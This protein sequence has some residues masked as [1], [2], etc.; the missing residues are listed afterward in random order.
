MKSQ[1][2]DQRTGAGLAGLSTAEF[3]G[4]GVFTL[5]L[6]CAGALLLA[7]LLLA[8]KAAAQETPAP[9][10]ALTVEETDSV[11]ALTKADVDAWLD[12]YMPYALKQGDIAGAVVSVVKDGE[13]LTS[14]GYGYADLETGLVPDPAETL[15]RAGSVSKLFTWTAIMQLVDQGELDLD[16]DISEYIDFTI[17]SS[18]ETPIT[19]RTL[20]T[21][22]PGFEE[23]L[24][25]LI[26]TNAAEPM[27]IEAYLKSGVPRVAFEPGQVPAYSNYGT[28]LAGYIVERTSGLSFDDYID[29]QIFGPLGMQNATFRQPLPEA[30]AANMAQ[31]Y[32]SFSDGEPKAFENVIAAPAGSLSITAEDIARFMIAHLNDGVPLL[33]A[34]TGREMHDTTS[35]ALPALHPM[36]LGFYRS[37]RN[38]HRVLRHGGDTAYFHSDLALFIDDNVGIFISMNSLGSQASTR[39]RGNLLNGFADRYF[40]AESST[41]P[42]ASGLSPAHAGEVAGHYENSRSEWSTYIAFPAMLGQLK[43]TAEKNGD[44]LTEGIPGV[45]GMGRRWREVE[46]YVWQDINGQDRLAFRMEDGKPVMLGVEPY[47]GV[48][49]YLP[50]PWWRNIGLLLPLVFA[51]CGFLLL[52]LVLW[53]V[54]A[55]VRRRYGARFPLSGSPARAYRFVRITSALMLAWL[56]GW[57]LTVMSMLSENANM[58]GS[59][60]GMLRGLQLAMILPLAALAAAGWNVFTVFTH[61]TSWLAKLSSVLIFLSCLIIVWFG[62]A[63]HLFSFNLNY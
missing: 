25:Y 26:L 22:T 23:K 45:N 49:V 9:A 55:L 12:G 1:A 50:P 21:H 15:F 7:A 42:A 38:G 24:K 8:G 11:P 2:Y 30:M 39:V 29:Q 52:T 5:V 35:A 51:A 56:A 57:F 16:T 58:D 62:L 17:P 6:Q 28:A 31:G 34:Q 18:Y 37:D 33:S 13:L 27:S 54:R 44:L 20:L 14:R 60:D 53:P 41:P 4:R 3:E 36:A 47:A 48:F 63:G 10:P 59:F 32:V 19:L 40:P 61:Q 43:V 46:P